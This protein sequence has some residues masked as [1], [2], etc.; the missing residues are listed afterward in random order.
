MSGYFVYFWRDW[1]RI[2]EGGVGILEAPKSEFIAPTNFGRCSFHASCTFKRFLLL[3][4]NQRKWIQER[5][6]FSKNT[7][8]LSPPTFLCAVSFFTSLPSTI[9]PHF[10]STL[11]PTRPHLRSLTS[12]FCP[13]HLRPSPCFHSPPCPTRPGRKT[14]TPTPDSRAHQ[15]E[16]TPQEGKERKG[17]K[18]MMI[19]QKLLIYISRER[20]TLRR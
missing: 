8:F 15:D 3:H 7:I 6:K 13:A 1:K 11:S 18:Q 19:N 20:G 4:F 2:P 10:N 16:R 9:H 12:S 5:K 17:K 14:A